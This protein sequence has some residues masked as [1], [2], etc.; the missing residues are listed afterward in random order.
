MHLKDA[1]KALHILRG[2]SEGVAAQVLIKDTSVL[3][4]L[5]KT[6]TTEIAALTEKFGLARYQLPLM[7]SRD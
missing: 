1:V 6:V 5:V 7:P 4:G 3:P 2:D